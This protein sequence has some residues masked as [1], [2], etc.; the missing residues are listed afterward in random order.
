VIL[1]GFGREDEKKIKK[2]QKSVD[3][4]ADR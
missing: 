2:F 1:A 4:G 3:K